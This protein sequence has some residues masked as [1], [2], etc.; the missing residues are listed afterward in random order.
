MRLFNF[1]VPFIPTFF[2][3]NDLQKEYIL[4]KNMVLT[5]TKISLALNKNFTGLLNNII[6]IFLQN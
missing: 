5:N 2:L 4:L 3:F 6:D 1:N